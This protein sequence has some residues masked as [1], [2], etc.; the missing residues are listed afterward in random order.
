MLDVYKSIYKL[1][2][3]PF[4][5]S[6][7]Y[8]FSF[9][10]RSYDDAKSYLK[11]AITEGEGIVAITGAP[12]TGKTTLIASII[13]EL[14]LTQ[15]HVGVVTNVQLDSSSLLDMVIDAFSL[16]VDRSGH[17]SAM[18]ELKRFLKNQSEEG[19]RV[20]LIVD[21]AQGLS[22]ALLEELRLLSNL[23]H[24]T[25]LVLQVFLVG[26][27]PLMDI[28]RSP[29]MEQLHQRLIAAAQLK[30]LTFEETRDYIVYRMECV[31]W[32]N[33]PV[34]SEE[35]YSLIYKF[36]AGVPRR[37]NLICHRLFIHA[38]LK[39]KHDLLGG[40]AL[41]VIVELHREG[42]LTPVARRALGEYVGG[43]K[44]MAAS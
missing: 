4:R 44:D 2:G 14:D 18:S 23:Q 43:I 37:I 35:A 29:G 17:I 20:I 6:P 32:K 19:R 41:Q 16:Q 34:I 26:Q 1:E 9:G 11:Y 27:E 28:I 30:A 33:D 21:E 38:G 15:V 40:D 3:S 13:S 31:G 42:L 10:H 24:N 36:S 39:E 7:D 22:D 25:Q 12:G 5:L 8:R